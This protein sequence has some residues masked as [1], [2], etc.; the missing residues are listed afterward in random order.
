MLLPVLLAL[1][2]ASPAEAEGAPRTFVFAQENIYAGHDYH[3]KNL[4]TSGAVRDIDVLRYAV[5]DVKYEVVDGVETATCD[6]ID[7]FADWA[8]FYAAVESVDGVAD[9]WE[10]GA[11][12]GSL[13]QLKKL[14]ARHPRL[15]LLISL[16]GP[17]HSLH[18]PTIAAS[19]SL[20]RAFVA[21]CVGKW[22]GGGVAATVEPRHLW[23]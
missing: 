23:G 13:N 11:L 5:S 19:P 21:D 2:P 14:K 4:E 1:L 15:R 17:A 22:I 12:R 9:T 3:V 8:R 16:G 18:S 10:P 7:A 6:T 20:R